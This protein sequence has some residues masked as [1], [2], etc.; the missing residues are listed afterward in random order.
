MRMANDQ[1][2]SITCEENIREVG[3]SKSPWSNTELGVPSGS[4]VFAALLVT[5][6]TGRV[7]SFNLAAV[8]RQAGQGTTQ[9]WSQ[10]WQAQ[11]VRRRIN[12]MQPPPRKIRDG[13]LDYKELKLLHRTTEDRNRL[14]RIAAVLFF[15]PQ[16]FFYY[17][18]FIRGALPSTFEGEEARKKRYRT[19]VETREKAA[20]ELLTTLDEQAAGAGIQGQAAVSHRDKAL[21]VLCAGKPASA[22]LRVNDYVIPP[23]DGDRGCKQLERL[24][25]KKQAREE[26]PKAK[27]RIGHV[28]GTGFHALAGIH[29]PLLKAS[30]KIAGISD[31]Y[32][33]LGIFRRFRRMAL[34][35]HLERLIEEDDVLV[36]QGGSTGL[37]HEELTDACLRRGLGSDE[38]GE[39]ELKDQLQ[40]WLGFIVTIRR[41]FEPHRATLA[42]ILIFARDSIRN[43]ST[44][45]KYL[46]APQDSAADDA[47]DAR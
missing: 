2:H 35:R 12:K 17:L 47:T 3:E 11:G 26:K 25:K 13:M 32:R 30:L 1:I 39:A 42:A 44:L 16:F 6:D 4:Q 34:G 20:I 24:K 41:K 31:R 29:E 28:T 8:F 21:L 33:S 5:A 15:I 37:S 9:Y 45:V 18:L 43:D 22:I 10:W 7:T 19:L 40:K 38:L 23:S 46:Y 14:L 27:L 36:R